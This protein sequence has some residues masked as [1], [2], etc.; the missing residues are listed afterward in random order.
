MPFTDE[1]I[2]RVRASLARLGFQTTVI[3]L[4]HLPC[5]VP[6]RP[7]AARK[8]AALDATARGKDGA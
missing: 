6:L 4:R 8:V 2:E 1:Q 7:A 5:S 3:D